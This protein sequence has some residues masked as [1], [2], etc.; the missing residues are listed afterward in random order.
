MKQGVPWKHVFRS[1]CELVKYI[2]EGLELVST[3]FRLHALQFTLLFPNKHIY[4]R[5]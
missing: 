2:V 1:V 3:T 4:L 5:V